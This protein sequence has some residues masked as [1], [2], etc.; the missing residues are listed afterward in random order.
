MLRGREDGY[1]GW[2]MFMEEQSAFV[3]VDYKKMEKWF[4]N[5]CRE[6]KLLYKKLKLLYLH[7][8]YGSFLVNLI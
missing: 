3:E 5:C 7:C 8:L 1:I 6:N 2:E 4:A